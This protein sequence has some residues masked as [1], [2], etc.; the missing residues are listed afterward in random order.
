MMTD[1]SETRACLQRARA[2]LQDAHLMVGRTNLPPSARP[3]AV[4]NQIDALEEIIRQ[5]SDEIEAARLAC[6]R[7]GRSGLTLV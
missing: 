6:S 7:E 4:R 2:A 3:V 5:A 1:Y